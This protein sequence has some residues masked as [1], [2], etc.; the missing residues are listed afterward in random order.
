[1]SSLAEKRPSGEDR[2]EERAENVEWVANNGGEQPIFCR[3][4]QRV[5]SLTVGRELAYINS[6]IDETVNSGAI[7]GC[8]EAT[9]C[10]G[11]I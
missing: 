6:S 5:E 1:M 8:G 11:G 3:V 7:L 2:G 4:N 9:P 10:R